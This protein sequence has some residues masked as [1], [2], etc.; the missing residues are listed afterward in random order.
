[1]FGDLGTAKLRRPTA[2]LLVRAE[3]QIE[4]QIPGFSAAG[5]RKGGF[6]Y[7]AFNSLPNSADMAFF[8]GGSAI[9]AT[10][11]HGAVQH[12]AFSDEKLAAIGDPAIVPH[13]S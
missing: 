5:R 1:M 8:S 4:P 6:A 7:A 10:Q 9:R 13:F 12:I 3:H 2:I 11:N